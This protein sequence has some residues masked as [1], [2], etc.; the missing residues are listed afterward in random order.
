MDAEEHPV[1]PGDTLVLCSDG[2]N[3]MA[4]DPDIGS[5]L[6]TSLSAREAVDR[7]ITL[8]NDNGGEDNVTVVVVRVIEGANGWLARLWRWLCGE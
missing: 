3:R 2:L 5:V 1:L 8:A 6:N 4:T 7:L